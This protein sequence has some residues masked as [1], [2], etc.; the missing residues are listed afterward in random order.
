[1]YPGDFMD[2]GIITNEIELGKALIGL[3]GFK[4]L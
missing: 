2:P 4:T 1:M 3:F